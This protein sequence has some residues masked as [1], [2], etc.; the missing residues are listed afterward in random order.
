MV[1][2]IMGDPVLGYTYP[3]LGTKSFNE[4]ALSGCGVEGF[5]GL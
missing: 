4:T 2:R 3:N 1:C 5:G